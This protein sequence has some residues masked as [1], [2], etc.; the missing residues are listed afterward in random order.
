[1]KTIRLFLC[2]FC[3]A[4]SCTKDNNDEPPSENPDAGFNLFSVQDDIDFGKKMDAEI[5]AT[6]SEYPVLN[7]STNPTAYNNLERIRDSLVRSDDVY[8]KNTFE[9]QVRIIKDDNIVNAFCTPGGYM[10]FYT[11]LI[12]YLDNEA[13]FAGV[14]AHEM[15]HADKRHVTEQMT[16]LYGLQILFSML[17]GNDPGEMTKL[18]ADLAFGLGALQFSRNNEYEADEYAVKYLSSTAYDPKGISG[19][20]EKITAG[21]SPRP[22]E[23]LSTHPDP[24]NR[25]DAINTV[26]TNL[27]S[28]VG[29]TFESQY[30]QFKNSLP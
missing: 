7:K 3:I 8:F 26:W 24:G 17:M 10:Y 6:P 15:A 2:L 18:I 11:G 12:K 28:P 23:F 16:K 22:P 1:M 29:Q 14:M 27:G 19:F 30:Q 4:S 21:A 13:Q 9:W 20:F 5:M 25:L